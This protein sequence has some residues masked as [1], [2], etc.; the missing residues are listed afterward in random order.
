MEESVRERVIELLNVK[1]FF[2]AFNMIDDIL[3]NEDEKEDVI[4]ILETAGENFI[5]EEDNESAEKVFKK[6]I[7]IEP[8]NGHFNLGLVYLNVNKNDDAILNFKKS[9]EYGNNSSDVYKFTGMAYMNKEDYDNAIKFLNKAISIEENF[10]NNHYLGL[11]YLGKED[12]DNAIKFLSKAC[13]I[14]ENYE[15]LHYLGLAYLGKED[16]DNAIK[17]FTKSIERNADF[18]DAYYYRGMAFY[19]TGNERE[20]MKDYKKACELNNEYIDMPYEGY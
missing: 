19:A 11:A 8:L 16:Y 2:E 18:A 3:K 6:E 13:N 20:A 12:Y 4:E 1:N 7:L 17:F 5:D 10:E 9:I 14:K 15:T